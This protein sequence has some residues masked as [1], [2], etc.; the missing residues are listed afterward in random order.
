MEQLIDAAEHG[1]HGVRD[2]CMIRTAWRHGLR[3]SELVGLELIDVKPDERTIYVRRAK[4]SISADHPLIESEM[5]PLKA[6]LRCRKALR[7]A[8]SPYLFI[9]ERGDAFERRGV[10]Y[11][12]RACAKRAGFTFACYPHILRHSCARHLADKGFDAF[13]IAGYLGHKNIQNSLRYVHTS[14]AQFKDMW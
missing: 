6:W 3:V 8:E 14:S 11:L 5:R 12:L 4:G 1:R 10:N 2:A 9:N 13:R 7:G